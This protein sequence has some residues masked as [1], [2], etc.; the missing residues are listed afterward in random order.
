MARTYD[1]SRQIQ[2]YSR[3]NTISRTDLQHLIDGMKSVGD[4]Q[5]VT[6]TPD[7]LVIAGLT[8]LVD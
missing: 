5:G 4:L 8:K 3:E 1:L 7:Q 2:M 6:I